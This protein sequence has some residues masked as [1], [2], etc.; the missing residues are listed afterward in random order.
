MLISHTW[1]VEKFSLHK[2]LHLYINLCKRSLSSCS[3]Y[4]HF[5]WKDVSSTQVQKL[6]NRF[7]GSA[8]YKF[9]TSNLVSTV[10]CIK[11]NTLFVVSL[12][13]SANEAVVTVA[14]LVSRTL[15]REAKSTGRWR[16]DKAK[17]KEKNYPTLVAHKSPS[18]W[19]EIYSTC[20]W[21]VFPHRM[22]AAGKSVASACHVPDWK[23]SGGHWWPLQLHGP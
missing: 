11:N 20:L 5:R 21:W 9:L 14:I 4:D 12:S 2:A 18:Y 19:S 23:T 7:W 13:V 3:G 8:F 10:L 15:T 1:P 22:R 16:Q 6:L 17:S